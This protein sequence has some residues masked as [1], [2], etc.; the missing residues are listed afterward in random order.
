MFSPP[1]WMIH[2]PPRKL[3]DTADGLHYLHSCNVVHGD[4][5]GVRGSSE[6]RF[7]ILTPGQPNVLVDAAGRA[8][9]TDFGLAQDLDAI[10]SALN[11]Q[12]RTVRWTAPE[13]L[14]EEGTFSKEAD[15]FSF[16]MVMIEVR[17]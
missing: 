10:Q 9:I 15:V 17:C 11:D 13:I 6:S 8:R 4:L 3:R 5:K 12:G 2:L 1:S 7:T 14:N 16:A